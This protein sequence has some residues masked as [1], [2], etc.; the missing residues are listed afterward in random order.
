M[1]HLP[2]R[3]KEIPHSPTR[4]FPEHSEEYPITYPPD[5][6]GIPLPEEYPFEP[7]EPEINP[8]EP[9]VDPF[10]EPLDGNTYL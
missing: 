2:K 6:P 9:F 3:R 5:Y 10:D 4:E 7:E 1:K 8:S